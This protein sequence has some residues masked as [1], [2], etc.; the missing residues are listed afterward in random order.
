MLGGPMLGGPM[1]GETIYQYKDAIV[2]G[3]YSRIPGDETMRHP[4]RYRSAAPLLASLAALSI[5][6]TACA[7]NFM[8]LSAKF[9][10]RGGIY[11][12][13]IAEHRHPDW[14]APTSPN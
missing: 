3:T 11:T 14:Q 2:P 10:V 4:R 12:T 6:V 9:N 13:V 8:R 7:P 1:L 5:L